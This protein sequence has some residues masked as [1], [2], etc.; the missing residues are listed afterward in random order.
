MQLFARPIA[1]TLKAIETVV[2]AGD[3]CRY[4][5]RSRLYLSTVRRDDRHHPSHW[6]TRMLKSK[7]SRSRRR[8]SS[9]LP[10]L[11]PAIGPQ[12]RV[13]NA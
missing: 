9:K 1:E 13:R 6:M 3:G 5:R 12:I 2:I 4:L 11:S 8:S 7:P 10:Y